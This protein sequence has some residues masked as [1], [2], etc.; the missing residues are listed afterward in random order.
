M[1]S[2]VRLR[3]T[4]RLIVVAL[5]VLVGGVLVLRPATQAPQ[6]AQAAPLA[7]PFSLPL[8]SGGTGTLALRALRGHPVVLNFFQSNCGPC[9]DEMP[10]LAQTSRT[11]RRQGVV[12]LGIAS[13]GDAA[14]AARGL[15][16]AD[17]L[18]FPVVWDE[19]QAVAWQYQV[20]ATPS[21]MFIDAQ[22]RWRGQY[23]GQLDASLIRNGLAQAG[24]IA[25]S[26]CA[27]VEP[28]G[29]GVAGTTTVPASALRVTK[30]FSAPYRPAAPFAL[31]DQQGRLI[32]PASL[33]GKVVALTFISAACVEQC[34]LVGQ[35]LGQAR[36]LLGRAASRLS[37]VAI[38][39]APEQDSAATTR[40][41]AREAGW[42]GADW[43][44]L[45][46]PRAT[47]QRVWNAYWVPVYAP[48]PIFKTTGAGLVHQTGLYLIDP[49]GRLRAYD[50]VPFLAADV[51]ASVR[52]LL[53]EQ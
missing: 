41:F 38:S 2:V 14:S 51:A 53:G 34:P 25:C 45:T 18:P 40:R 28:P 16:R 19:H 26:T 43:H 15:A 9:L 24:A 33:R 36:R 20:S 30:I 27:A 8:L 3:S 49:R 13:L 35:T 17:H 23:E 52:A 11:Y 1:R 42:L 31:P 44:Y 4:S 6:S 10:L 12:V 46:A 7:P 5:V 29:E 39:V 32:T 47:L 21:T 37:I 48:P 50:D 22:G